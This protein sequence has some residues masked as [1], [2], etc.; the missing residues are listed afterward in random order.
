MSTPASPEHQ[1]EEASRATSPTRRAPPRYK[2]ALMTWLGA[3]VV[4]TIILGVLG[5]AMSRWPLFLRTL[6]ISGLMVLTLT[7][8]VLP[9]LTYLLRGWLTRR[10]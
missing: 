10:S 1:S 7:W 8:I 9:A 2:L 5:P 6:V 3:Y 4:I